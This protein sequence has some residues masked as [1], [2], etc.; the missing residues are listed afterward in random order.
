[1]PRNFLMGFANLSVFEGVVDSAEE[2]SSGTKNALIGAYS[3]SPSDTRSEYNIDAD[4]DPSWDG[5]SDW[6]YTDLAIQVRQMALDD[7]ARFT[8]DVI[9]PSGTNAGELI[10]GTSDAP[11][12]GLSFSALRRDGG[13]RLYRYFRCKLMS[14]S[15]EHQT[16]GTEV[17]AQNYTLNIRAYHRAYDQQVRAT[18]DVDPGDALTWLDTL[19]DLPVS[20]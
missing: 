16:K 15:V 10:E 17:A 2:Y 13:Y 12:V 11:I 18:K 6:E 7:L 3:C 8:G 14:Y 9:A 20:P 5:G 1:M 4:D 19:G